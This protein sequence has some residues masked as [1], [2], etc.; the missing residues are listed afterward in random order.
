MSRTVLVTGGSRGV[1]REIVTRFAELGDQVV[2]VA[3]DAE[4]LAQVAAEVSGQVRAVSC[5]V[6][7]EDAVARLMRDVG[8]VDVLVNNAGIASSAR[9]NRT[10]LE[11]WNAHMAV[12]A[13]AVFLCTRAVIGEMQARGEGRIITVASVA[14]RVGVAYAGAYSASKHAAVGVTRSAAAELAGSRATANAVCPAFVDSEMTAASAA[15]IAERTGRTLEESIDTLA[16]L[17][18]LNRLVKPGE[19]A[20]IVVWLA[21]CAAEAV[22]GQTIVLDG[23]GVQA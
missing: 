21:S 22:N 12:N 3:R 5:D 13:T 4:M 2:A 20:D 1:G 9:L 11:S 14:G 7:D 23:G 19:V 8:Q 17:S 18:P 6:T 10:T 16:R 15:R